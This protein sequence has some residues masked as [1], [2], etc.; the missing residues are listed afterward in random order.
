MIIFSCIIS[1]NRVLELPEFWLD[2]IV[3]PSGGDGLAKT[4]WLPTG[5]EERS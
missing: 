4:D 3:R 1:S 2:D 5:E